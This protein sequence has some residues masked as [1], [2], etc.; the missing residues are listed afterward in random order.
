MFKSFI[1]VSVF[2][3]S[4]AGVA[5]AGSAQP[6]E[7]SAVSI[8][9][10]PQATS[11]SGFYA[12]GQVSTSTG[13]GSYYENDVLITTFVN[14]GLNGPQAGIF[15][16]YNFDVGSFVLGGELAYSKGR[17]AFDAFPAYYVDSVLDL[18]LRAGKSFGSVLVY[19]V[20]GGSFAN[21]T[22]NT[23]ET[24]ST[25]GVNYGAGVEYQVSDR[26]FV[27][28]EYL[29]RDIMSENSTVNTV[30]KTN[31]RQVMGSIQFRAGM[32]F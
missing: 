24:L 16:G 28:L 10:P 21:Y 23:F 25:S 12:G 3:V 13:T 26:V 18:K 4:L 31:Y 19:G 20:V 22:R 32:R 29:A 5:L 2:S 7:V 11:W 6:A 15:A 1:A 9:P 8:T 30:P 27:G 17:I 14:A